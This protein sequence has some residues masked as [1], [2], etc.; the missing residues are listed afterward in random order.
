[1]LK[2]YGPTH[3]AVSGVEA[4]EAFQAS[5]EAQEPYDLICLDIMMPEMDGQEALKEI[6]KLEEERRKKDVVFSDTKILMTTALD[7][8][9]NVKEALR[10]RCDGYLLKPLDQRKLLDKLRELSLIL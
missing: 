7:D 1:V 5:V 4:V 3:V 2:E 10:N 6:R 8:R 9:E